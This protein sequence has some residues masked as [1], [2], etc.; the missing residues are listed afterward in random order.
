MGIEFSSSSYV[1][2]PSALTGA[3]ITDMRRD[4][5]ARFTVLHRVLDDVLHRVLEM[6]D[7]G[8]VRSVYTDVSDSDSRFSSASSR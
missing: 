2:V 7:A 6:K 4:A 5:N 1:D 8:D 3:Y